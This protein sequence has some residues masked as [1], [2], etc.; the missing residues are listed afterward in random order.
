MSCLDVFVGNFIAIDTDLY[1]LWLNGYTAH[2]AALV[3]DKQ[4]VL[5]NTGLGMDDLIS[6]VLDHYRLFI[7]LEKML[8]NPVQLAEQQIYQIDSETQKIIIDRYYRFDAV[9]VREVLGRKLSSRNRKDMEDVSEKTRVPLRS[10]RRQFDNMKRVFKVVEDLMGS[11]VDNIQ[12]HF[13]LP[14]DLAM[15]YAAIVFIANNRF[16]TTKKKLSHLTF[17]DFVHCAEQMITNWS[18]SS[19]ECK[20]HQDMDVDLDREFLQN[21]RDLKLFLEK[22]VIDEHRN[23]VL[24]VIKP[25]VSKKTY[26]D[27]EENFKNLSKA[28][29]NIA[30]GL[31]HSKEARDIF[32]DL[33]EKITEPCTHTNWT[34]EELECFLTA[35]GDTCIKLE[36][37]RGLPHLVSVWE[38]YMKTLSSCILQIYH[39]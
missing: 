38:R 27:L 26:Q 10:C 36:L 7:N 28:I 32:I 3:L 30:Y 8:K 9:V 19:V 20:G 24:Q 6:D 23:L 11:L 13:L 18:Y 22:D 33:V 12:R 4:G 14:E 5:Q 31:N 1:E 34:K 25:S 21:L 17:D 2:D 15:Q 35:Y 37:F 29:I 16:E 39:M